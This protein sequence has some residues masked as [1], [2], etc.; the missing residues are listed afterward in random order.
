VHSVE[1]SPDGRW[2]ATGSYRTVGMWDARS[3]KQLHALAHEGQVY[4]VAFSPDGRW[5]A[6]VVGDY[7][8]AR[9]W[10]ARSGKQVHTLTH[11]NR[12]SAVAFSIDGLW[13]A[14]GGDGNR[15]ALWRITPA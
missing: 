13:L 15:A 2:L 8:T 3:G 1:F 5:L 10:D 6:T 9:I 12:V 4:A 14:T 11:D 7:K